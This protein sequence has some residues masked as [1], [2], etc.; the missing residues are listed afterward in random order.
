MGINNI[1]PRNLW[2][3][4]IVKNYNLLELLVYRSRLLGADLQVTNFGGGNTSTKLFL[5]DPLTKKSKKIDIPRLAS[6]FYMGVWFSSNNKDRN[7]DIKE[8]ANIVN[9]NG[10]DGLLTGGGMVN[11]MKT[12]STKM[13]DK[14]GLDTDQ[15]MKEAT[16]ICG[17]MEGNPLFNSLLGMQG[18]MFKGMEQGKSNDTKKINLDKSTHNPDITKERLQRKSILYLK[19]KN[20]IKR[21]N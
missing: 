16:E 17:S 20:R 5:K 19:L 14:E 6:H 1:S 18:D 21:K 12:I 8:Q 4:R 2:N 10:I 9:N 15:L 13:G 7:F 3:D 11:M